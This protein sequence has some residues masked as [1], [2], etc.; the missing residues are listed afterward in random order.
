MIAMY[1]VEDKAQNEVKEKP[2]MNNKKIKWIP[3]IVVSAVAALFIIAATWATFYFS[4]PATT[5]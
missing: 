4:K 3:I 1:Q 5:D 2:E